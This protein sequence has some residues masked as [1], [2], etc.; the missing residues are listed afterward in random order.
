MTFSLLKK[1]IVQPEGISNV[2]TEQCLEK[3]EFKKYVDVGLA[4]RG[5]EKV[6]GSPRNVNFMGDL[7]LLDEFDPFICKLIEQREL[8]PKSLIPYLSKTI[9]EQIIE[10]MGKKII[11]TII[12]QINN[13]NTKYC[14]I[15]MDSASDLS[16]NDQLAIVLRYCFLGKVYERCAP[17]IRIS[18]HIGL[19]L[20]N[21]VQEFLERNKL[22]LDNCRRQSFDNA[23]N[24]SC[25]F[26]GV[27]VLLKEKN[28][29]NYEPCAAY[30]L[31]LDR[32]E[33]VKVATEIV[34]FFVLVQQKCFLFCFVP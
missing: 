6:F 27:Q 17:L 22:L 11:K 14:S 30:S 18:S 20:F 29:T 16:Y 34:N 8:R 23:A 12:T 5:T 4:F 28:I 1:D 13:D 7:E 26:N 2:L 31:N 3:V 15:V 33:L 25:Q 19:Y 32:V 9:Y 21:S 10:I 24:M